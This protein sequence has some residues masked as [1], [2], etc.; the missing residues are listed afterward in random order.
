MDK[1]TFKNLPGDALEGGEISYFDMAFI[2]IPLSVDI[3]SL[4]DSNKIRQEDI[5]FHEK[6][7]ALCL[8]FTCNQRPPC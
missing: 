5:W 7:I 2:I 8:G 4:Q 1:L 3:W 6:L